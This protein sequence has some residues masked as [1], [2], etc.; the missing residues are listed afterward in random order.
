MATG[1]SAKTAIQITDEPECELP[2]SRQPHTDFTSDIDSPS[3]HTEA[4]TLHDHPQPNSLLI[5]MLYT[6][7]SQRVHGL[8]LLRDGLRCESLEVNL[9]YNVYTIDLGHEPYLA[10][11][12]RHIRHD[13]T[14]DGVLFKMD[15]TWQKRTNFKTEKS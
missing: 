2:S 1:K 9:H 12:G 7:P 6:R 3:R 10:I 4:T 14:D 15:T 5:G 11:D 8:Q 13:F